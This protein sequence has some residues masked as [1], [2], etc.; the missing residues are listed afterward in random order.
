MSDGTAPGRAW[1][2]VGAALGVGL[3][4][5]GVVR[6]GRDAATLPADAVA[7]VGDSPI[8]RQALDDAV[9]A[10]TEGE[11]QRADPE[12]RRHALERLVD[13]RLLVQAALAFGLPTRDAKLREDLAA[14]MRE[15]VT[16]EAVGQ[17]ADDALRAYEEAHAAP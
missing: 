10:D 14:A 16:G 5:R 9:A 6:S 11:P 2:L 7:L 3:A 13:E 15:N 4:V 8:S 12:V 17:P 1:L